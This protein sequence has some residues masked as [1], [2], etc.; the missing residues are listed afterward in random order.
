MGLQEELKTLYL[1]ME[2]NF[3]HYVSDE[4]ISDY[5]NK[6]RMYLLDLHKVR[7]NLLNIIVNS[8]KNTLF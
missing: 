6:S 8:Q 5:Y 2:E 4:K 3:Q 1:S 7:R